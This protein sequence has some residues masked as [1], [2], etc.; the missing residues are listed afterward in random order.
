MTIKTA[1]KTGEFTC[2]NGIFFKRNSSGLWALERRELEETSASTSA[3]NLLSFLPFS[4]LLFFKLPSSFYFG[5]PIVGDS[6]S[7]VPQIGTRRFIAGRQ[8]GQYVREENMLWY[9]HSLKKL[10]YALCFN[11]D[12]KL[13]ICRS[14]D[15]WWM[16]FSY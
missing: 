6:Y 5:F 1:R 4:P 7:I 11:T 13:K 16:N 9:F 8:W 12:L 2:F 10:C 14:E 15:I 3:I